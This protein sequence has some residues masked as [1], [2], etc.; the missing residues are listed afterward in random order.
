V[1]WDPSGRELYF[2]DELGTLREAAVVLEGKMLA[3]MEREEGGTV[4]CSRALGGTLVL[5]SIAILCLG[6][7]AADQRQEDRRGNP[8]KD[9]EKVVKSDAEWKKLLT[10]LQYEVTR[11]K[12]TERAF[13]GE[14]WDN[15]E[16]G[17]YTCVCC[18][19]KLFDSGTK[20]DSGTGWPSFTSPVAPECVRLE[21]DNSLFMKRTEVVCARCGAHLGHVFD[22]G[23]AP[24]GLRYCINSAS[25]DFLKRP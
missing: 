5:G 15:H 6:F 7:L 23:P 8:A 3:P 25:L 1:P 11:R 18:G 20:F 21:V 19:A 9:S 12:G 14:Y 13:T 2:S 24:T 4:R 10:P 17:V 16:S 22:D